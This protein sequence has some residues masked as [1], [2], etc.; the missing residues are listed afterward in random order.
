MA[1]LGTPDGI[2]LAFLRILPVTEEMKTVGN[3]Y[4]KRVGP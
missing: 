1:F 4:S 2:N 3:G